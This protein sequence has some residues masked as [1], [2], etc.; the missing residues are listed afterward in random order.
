MRAPANNRHKLPPRQK[1]KSI[2]KTKTWDR[3]E[4][5]KSGWRV[6]KGAKDKAKD[7]D[8]E[9]HEEEPVEFEQFPRP[10][11][12]GEFHA[13]LTFV[14]GRLDDSPVAVG[15]HSLTHNQPI[16]ILTCG[17]F[18]GPSPCTGRCE[19]QSTCVFRRLTRVFSTAT[20]NETHC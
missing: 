19:T 3:T 5:A 17:H 1:G 12:L 11:N 20:A 14:T 6:L 4:C 18:P 2:K 16:R 15:Y 8:D 7:P 10:T 13:C 9:V